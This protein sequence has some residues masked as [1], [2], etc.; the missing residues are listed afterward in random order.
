MNSAERSFR[1]LKRHI[2]RTNAHNLK[3]EIMI[4]GRSNRKN[5]ISEATCTNKAGMTEKFMQ[6]MNTA[7][8]TM[9]ISA[10]RK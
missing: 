1:P 9:V 5:K 4:S 10:F 6:S 2:R 7:S 8:H 3:K